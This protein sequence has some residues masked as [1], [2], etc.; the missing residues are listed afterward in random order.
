MEEEGRKREGER[1]GGGWGRKGKRGERRE[2][3]GYRLKKQRDR[4]RREGR[5]MMEGVERDG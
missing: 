2:K 3:E 1:R 5:W 4:R